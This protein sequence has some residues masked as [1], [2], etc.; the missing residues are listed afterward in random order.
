MYN[1]IRT[2]SKHIDVKICPSSFRF[3]LL[4]SQLHYHRET[5]VPQG[6]TKLGW[7]DRIRLR[8]LAVY[9]LASTHLLPVDITAKWVKVFRKARKLHRKALS[10][11]LTDDFLFSTTL[12]VYVAT[13]NPLKAVM[14]NVAS[15]KDVAQ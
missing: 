10:A 3:L 7:L 9:Q 2:T 11:G 14:K 4:C 6:I 13:K 8:R 12:E 15:A 1:G 5:M